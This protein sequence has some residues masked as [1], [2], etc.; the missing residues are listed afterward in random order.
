[1]NAAHLALTEELGPW[2]LALAVVL[3]LGLL[4]LYTEWRRRLAWWLLVSGL[5]AELAL[6]GAV[7]RP[8]WVR[9]TLVPNGARL[10]LLRDRSRRLELPAG[11]GESRAQVAVRVEQKLRQQFAG[12]AIETLY[13]GDGPLSRDATSPTNGPPGS[14][15]SGALE[16]MSALL[17]TRPDSVILL[18]DGRFS[19][20]P[21]EPLRGAQEGL[22]VHT[23]DVGGPVPR[24]ASIRSVDTTGTAVAH[25]PFALRLELGCAP[26]RTCERLAVAV[27]ELQQGVEPTALAHAEVQFEPGATSAQL[28]LELT[29][30]RAGSRVLEL[31]ITPPSGDAVPAN[32]RRILTFNVTRERLRILHVA[33]RPS[34]D[35]RAMR[36]WLKSDAG[37]DLVS[38]F[39]LRTDGD[40]P[41]VDA[42]SELALIQFPVDDLFTTQLATFDAVILEDIDAARYHLDVHLEALARYVERGGGL[43][44][45][46]GPSAFGGGAYAGTPLE[47]VLP[48][49]LAATERPFDTGEFVPR[50]TEQGRDA[51]LL[52][53]LRRWLAEQL[54]AFAGANTLGNARPGA[55]VLW[56]H[57]S[58]Q[59][60][61]VHG[62]P[63]GALPILAI[64]EVKDGRVVALGI[65]SSFRLAWGA[66]EVTAGGRAYEALWEGLLGWVMREPRFE[67]V[68]GELVGECVAGG[69]ARLAFA[70]PG[71]AKGHLDV[72]VEPL[73]VRNPTPQR[74]S[75]ELTPGVERSEVSFPKLAP[76][77]YTARA[78]LGA[79]PASRFDFGCETGG[80][81]L[82]DSRPDPEALGQV[83]QLT[84]G[85]SVRPNRISDL[86]P[87]KSERVASARQVTPLLPAWLWAALASVAL[88]LTYLTRRAAG[89]V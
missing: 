20:L 2:G 72:T 16:G 19:R 18:S 75:L 13:F 46:G 25:Q 14:D 86:P 47:R 83:A 34:Y 50:Y 76:G 8:V 40:D 74:Q 71:G 12:L 3:L 45:V 7:L 10:V 63:R 70:R 23:V 73:G 89:L 79:G 30:E 11:G 35:V 21:T 67:A 81:A 61:P 51:A 41:N 57:P 52:A 78:R 66:A 77:G 53:P 38:F 17:G 24:D 82:A 5:V 69:P 48:V 58:R 29:L 88:G 22:T 37:I 85:R 87:P 36:N 4:R 68:R 56:E 1:M 32:D 59:S 39:I 49:S 9:E 15:L 54:P 43:I 27:R 33:G 42:D 64:S 31:E 84:G 6:L 62:G 55:L 44:L 26:A 28:D 80:R 65:D 60:L